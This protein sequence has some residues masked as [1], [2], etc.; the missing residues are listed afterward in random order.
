MPTQTHYTKRSKLP[1]FANELE[2]QKYLETSLC[3]NLKQFI[4]ISV[5]TMVK[6]EMEEI[7]QKT[8]DLLQFNGSYGRNMLTQAGLITDIPIPRF[9]Q[10]LPHNLQLDS[11]S[12][13]DKEQQKFELMVSQMHLLGISQRKIE[14]L[15]KTCFGISFSKN[16]VG[17]IYKE[18][19]EQQAAQVNTAPLEDEYEYLF[20]DGLWEVTKGYGWEENKSVLICALGVKANGERQLLGFTLARSEDTES[21]ERLIENIYSRG[22]H[23]KKLK[24]IISDDNPAFKKA[25]SHYYPDSKYQNCIMHKMRNVL[26]KTKHKHKEAIGNDLKTIFSQETLEAAIETVKVVVKRWYTVEPAAMEALRFNV[27]A[28]FTYLEFPKEVWRKIRTTNL[29]ERELREF[30]RRMKVFDNTFQSNESANRYAGSI[31]HYLNNNYPLRGGL[32][33]N[34]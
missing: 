7:R 1:I 29:L 14:H 13:F 19:A 33:T 26:K 20:L 9:R 3:E 23:G 21:I 10:G 17:V 2:L 22:L 12:I 18:L 24:L 25:A 34:A 11:M 8:N 31:A 30:R 15:A 27:E 4:K 5:N 28:C 16:R 6:A 32:H